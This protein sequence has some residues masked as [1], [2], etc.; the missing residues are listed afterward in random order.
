MKTI[1]ALTMP[2][3][4][5][6]RIISCLL[7]LACEFL[8]PGNPIEQRACQT[9]PHNPSG[10]PFDNKAT[11]RQEVTMNL[12]GNAGD[13][14][15]H[16]QMAWCIPPENLPAGWGI[17]TSISGLKHKTEINRGSRK[18]SLLPRFL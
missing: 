6:F 11:L 10:G 4:S 8:Q 1:A 18:R 9:L 17:S 7:F 12:P 3:A 16:E 5:L 15:P 14:Y 13:D 2:A